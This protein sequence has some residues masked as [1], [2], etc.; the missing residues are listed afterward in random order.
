MRRAAI[1]FLLLPTIVQASKITG[2]VTDQNGHGLPFATLYIEGTTTG[3][4]T[5]SQG[6]FSLEVPTGDHTIVF[7]Y[8]GYK[9][10]RKPVSVGQQD[11]LLNIQLLPETVELKEIVI[12][13]SEDPA[14]RVIREAIKKRKY[15]LN[16]VN[17]YSCDVY[18]KGLQTLQRRP[19]K[20]FGITVTI[21]TGIVY[22]SESVSKFNFE[23]PDKIKETMISSKVSGYNSAFSFNQASEMR[24]NLYENLLQYKG[25]TQRGIVSPIANNAFLFYDY[26][27][28]GTKIEKGELINKIKVI[29]KRVND[30]VFSGYVY[31]MEDSW[32]IHSTDLLLTRSNQIEFVDSLWIS[33]VFAP[34]QDDIWMPL[35]QKFQFDLNVFGFEGRGSFVGVYSNYE[36]EPAREKRYFNNEVLTIQ[37]GSNKRDSGYWKAIRPIPLTALERSDYKIKDSLEVIRESR[38]YKDSVD[39]KTNKITGGNIF[40]SGYTYRNTFKKRFYHLDP[41]TEIFPIQYRGGLGRQC[42]T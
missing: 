13:A 37:E 10:V 31:I 26:E 19:D 38:P 15:Y 6:N 35:S 18:I 32:R 36:V 40:V 12:N 30:P 17:S 42:Q 41:I 4:T 1:F 20:I 39:R 34:V 5:N 27:L 3:T 9:T 7:Q 25:L 21:D 24:V 22:L 14:D 29:P 8:L 28:V 23:R 11:V 2:L 16:Q 33:Q